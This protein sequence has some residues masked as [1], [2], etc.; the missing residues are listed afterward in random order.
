MDTGYQDF[1][2][3]SLFKITGIKF[4]SWLHATQRM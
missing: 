4:Y 3:R 2:Q 1:R